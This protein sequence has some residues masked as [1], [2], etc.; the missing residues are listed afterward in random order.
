MTWQKH[1]I[2]QAR[3]IELAPVLE[4]RGYRLTKLRRDNYVLPDHEGLIIKRHYWLWQAKKL[5]GNA[6]DFFIHV[7][8]LS[9]A[10]AMRIL[11]PK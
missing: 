2:R 1:E 6:I 9:F 7:E 8:G 3:Q 11:V 4:K 10:Q 5:K